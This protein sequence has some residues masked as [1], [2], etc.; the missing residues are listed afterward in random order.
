MTH[1]ESLLYH[2]V[3]QRVYSIHTNTLTIMKSKEQ[4]LREN[5]SIIIGIVFRKSSAEVFS[6]CLMQKMQVMSLCLWWRW[7]NDDH[8]D[9]ADDS[10]YDDDD[11][12][13]HDDNDHDDNDDDDDG[14]DDEFWNSGQ[15]WALIA[16]FSTDQLCHPF[17]KLHVSVPPSASASASAPAPASPS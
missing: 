7:H 10:D 1:A 12:N 15:E 3:L 16:N 17:S 9:D 8:D 4:L 2:P 5:Y 11:N 6:R 13:D 14:G